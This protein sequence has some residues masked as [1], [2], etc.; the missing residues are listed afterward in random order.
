MTS[1]HSFIA[2][3][4]ESGDDGLNKN[5]TKQGASN[6]FVLSAF[7]IR[8]S[9]DIEL[10][11]TRDKILQKISKQRK[12]LHMKELKKQD[13]KL[14]VAKEVSEIPSRVISILSNKFSITNS[15]RKDLYD[16]KNTYYNYMA[17]YLVE[18]ISA[19]CSQLRARVPE[20][21]GKVKIIFSKR[22][23][24][25]YND[26]KLY[27]EKLKSDKNCSINWNVIDIE[28]IDAMPHNQRAGLQLADVAAYSFFKA[29]EKN[30]L[31]MVDCSFCRYFINN[32]Y[33]RNDIALNN[34]VK[35][36]PCFEE[37]PEEEKPYEFYELFKK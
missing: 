25:S 18:R 7:I 24:L 35:I 5:N 26:F 8:A 32:V 4:D 13:H 9:I 10:P 17:R 29:V 22:G 2:Y 33:K 34:G 27:L 23:G 15:K 31:N 37:L 21:N 3:I 20:G 28:L 6:W 12:I 14:F 16:K 11:R 30:Q 19:C 36:I 1:N